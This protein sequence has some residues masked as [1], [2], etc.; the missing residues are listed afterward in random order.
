MNATLENTAKVIASETLKQLGGNKFLAMTGARVQGYNAHDNGDIDLQL[1]LK[2]NISKVK[3]LIIKYVYALD[4]YE[5]IFYSFKNYELK[6]VAKFNDVY[7]DELQ[8]KFTEVTG[9]ETHL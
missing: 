8:D 4:T 3:I 6:E 9:L 7:S 2:S 1:M 5:M